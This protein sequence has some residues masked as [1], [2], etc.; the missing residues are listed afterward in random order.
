M[1][2]PHGKVSS[3]LAELRR[4]TERADREPVETIVGRAD[5]GDGE[6]AAAQAY[7]RESGV[8]ER[9]EQRIDELRGEALRALDGAPFNPQ[10]LGMLTELAD[11]LTVR[12]A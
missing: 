11:R 10:G 3:V 5:V 1:D 4:S 12:R 6:L 8:V 2:I 7:L 9:L